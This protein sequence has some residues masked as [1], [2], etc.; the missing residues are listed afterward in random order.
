MSLATASASVENPII[1]RDPPRIA[2]GPCQTLAQA[3]RKAASEN[4]RHGGPGFF[5][6]SRHCEEVRRPHA[7]FAEQSASGEW[8]AVLREM[9]A[10]RVVPP[11][12]GYGAALA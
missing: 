1:V 4:D 11:L 10:S 9:P 7:Y 6:E 12:P 3:K 5:I 2:A 8:Y